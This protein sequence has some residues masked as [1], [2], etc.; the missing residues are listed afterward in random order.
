MCMCGKPTINGEPGYYWNTRA[1]PA[2]SYPVNPPELHDGEML[3][4]DEPG[5]CGGIDSHAYHFRLAINTGGDIFVIVRH[6][7]GDERFRVA[8]YM[9]GVRHLIEALKQT[10]THGRY[11]MLHLLYDVHHDGADKARDAE[12]GKW[13]RAAAEKRIKVRRRGGRATVEIV[14]PPAAVTA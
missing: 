4:F 5:R 6:G 10:D 7:G 13:T 11:W 14:A 8:A 12:R 1:V 3:V 9:P 2:S